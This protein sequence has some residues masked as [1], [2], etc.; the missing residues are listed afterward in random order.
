MRC[1]TPGVV[2]P[3]VKFRASRKMSSER[4]RWSGRCDE[5]PLENMLGVKG[6]SSSHISPV[7][8]VWW[9]SGVR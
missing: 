9:L 8:T 6:L 4:D 2:L 3:V 7:G 1:M 5:R